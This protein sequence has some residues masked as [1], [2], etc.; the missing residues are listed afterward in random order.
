M[1]ITS[2][3]TA[4]YNMIEQQIRPCEVVHEGVLDT[5]GKIP[6]EHFVPE[7][8]QNL[9]YADTHVPLNAQHDMMKPLQEALM[10]QALDVQAGDR[11]LEIGTGSGY[12]TA[13]LIAMGGEVTSYEI[14]PTLGAQAAA[15]LDGLGQERR[16]ELIIGDI[17][18]AEIAADSYDVIAVTGSVPMSAE[19]FIPWLAPGGRI[20]SIEGGP[21]MMQAILRTCQ[22]TDDVQTTILGETLITSLQ[23]APQPELFTF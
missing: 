21:P 19:M 3:E 5:L 23:Q 7:A 8:Y 10:L 4:R 16:A 11:V 1:P 22:A 9:A 20:Y 6:R 2:Q 13:C 17:F 12:I 15:A 14:D 18:Q